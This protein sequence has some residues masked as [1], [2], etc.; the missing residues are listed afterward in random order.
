MV[1]GVLR[2]IN[3]ANSEVFMLGTFAT[4]YLETY[5]FNVTSSGKQYHGIRV[6]WVLLGSLFASMAVC[7]V[8]AMLVEVVAYRRLRARGREP[9]RPPLPPARVGSALQTP[10]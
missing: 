10:Y 3:F 4:F 7:A 2:L 9:R 6:F 8:V 5:V 1:Y